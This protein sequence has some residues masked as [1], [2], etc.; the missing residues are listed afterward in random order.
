MTFD[1]PQSSS[2]CERMAYSSAIVRARRLSV[3]PSKRYGVIYAWGNKVSKEKRPSAES[4][5]AE[6]EAALD[7]VLPIPAAPK[8]G[9]LAH[10]SSLPAVEGAGIMTTLDITSSAGQMAL[11]AAVNGES[12]SLWDL[13]AGAVV[14]IQHIVAHFT[15]SVDEETGEERCG[16]ML[17]LI[18]PEGNYHT[19][20]QFAFRALQLVAMLRG[21][22]P[23]HPPIRVRPVR[24]RSRNKRDFQSIVLAE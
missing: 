24:V 4:G 23:W 21:A 3:T 16:P 15:T 17:T 19:G 13:P 7:A 6:A 22:P 2:A 11:I 12:A 20:S 9:L 8:L 18:G 10:Y 5:L 1:W 14:T